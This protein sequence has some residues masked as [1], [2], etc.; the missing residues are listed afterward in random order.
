MKATSQIS[1]RLS[2]RLALPVLLGAALGAG[3]AKAG[4]VD[5]LAQV[6]AIAP[7]G[8]WLHW[9]DPETRYPAGHLLA[10]Q[11]YPDTS[12]WWPNEKTGYAGLKS[13]TGEGTP[14]HVLYWGSMATC[15]DGR[16]FVN[17]GGHAGYSGIET[18]AFDPKTGHWEMARGNWT[19][20]P[21]P[22][23]SSCRRDPRS[24]A[25]RGSRRGPWSLRRERG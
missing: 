25:G 14:T 12:I 3:A 8:Q 4:Q 18:P 6:Q 15:P 10:G 17:G 1:R 20:P 19:T 21:G 23:R 22:T 5:T 11:D 13:G 24:R 2:R 7:P 16:I 9:S